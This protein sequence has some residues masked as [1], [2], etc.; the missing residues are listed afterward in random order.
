MSII[1]FNKN[2][3]TKVVIQ[4]DLRWENF[5]FDDGKVFFKGEK[6]FIKNIFIEFKK[7]KY[8]PQKI[9]KLLYR[10]NKCSSAI[11]FN[12]KYYICFTDFC[13]SYP[14][15]FQEDL[16]NILISNSYK[17]LK[18]KLENIDEESLNFVKLCGYS[19]GYN[20]LVKNIKIMMPGELFFSDGINTTLE[21]YFEYHIT[22]KKKNLSKKKLKI[23][24]S[25]IIDNIFEN[26]IIKA[27]NRPIWIPLS[28][29]LD[30]R[31]VL[32]KLHEKGYTNLNCFSYG[33]KN[34]SECLIA[35]KIAKA[36][37]TRWKFIEIK[38]KNYLNFY[39]SKEKKIL[40]RYSDNLQVVPNYQDFLVIRKMLREKIL[41]KDAII[42]NGQSGDFNTGNHIPESLMK[43][44]SFKDFLES[45]KKKHFFLI[46][47]DNNILFN[48]KIDNFFIDYLKSNKVLEKNLADLYE[49][50]EYEERQI[51]YVV[52]GQKTYDFLNINW[53]LPLWESEFVKFWTSVDK[54]YRFRQ[55]LY[56]EYL[57]DWNY[58]NLFRK[59]FILTSHTGL[60]ETL[61]KVIS[62]SLKMFPFKKKIINYF[63][64][65]SRYGFYY[66]FIT[67]T[68]YLRIRGKIK[69]PLSIHLLN[70]MNNH[71]IITKRRLKN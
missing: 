53:Y 41:P 34:N 51:K 64:Y 57:Y 14:I 35:E 12:N 28:G 25:S 21:K 37:N 19:L 38:K 69:S 67:F 3:N 55:N 17:Y 62:F 71:E 56:R 43:N 18:K 2:I 22:T 66:Q 10:F 39:S 59:N 29:G 20:T 27:N 24:L 33:L 42:I 4:K 36:L 8:D 65:F 9:K 5:S 46:N 63:D 49:K 23:Q 44:N 70:W 1:K 16:D 68:E 50:W 11:F 32:C 40:D 58:K 31:L 60:L 48:K 26:I 52:N 61:L 45:V 15:F 47:S 7:N 6:D 30:S 54:K 13:R